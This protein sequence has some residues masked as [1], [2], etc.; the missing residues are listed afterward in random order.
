MMKIRRNIEKIK[1]IVTAVAVAILIITEL[2]MTLITMIIMGAMRSNIIDPIMQI[3]ALVII[4]F[5]IALRVYI[6][7]VKPFV[8]FQYVVSGVLEIVFVLLLR[9]SYIIIF[10]MEIVVYV[11]MHVLEYWVESVI[12]T[13]TVS[14]QMEKVMVSVVRFYWELHALLHF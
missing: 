7:F 2:P 6:A 10:I 11:V 12:I 1:V 3:P 14:V 4:V 8:K 9:I 5:M 13:V